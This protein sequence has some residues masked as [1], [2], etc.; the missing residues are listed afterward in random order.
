MTPVRGPAGILIAPT[1]HRQP[2]VR[3][4][5]PARVDVETPGSPGDERH[6]I[7]L[8][9]PGRRV[10]VVDFEAEAAQVSPLVIHDVDLWRA[11]P[12]RGES[13][14]PPGGRPCRRGVDRPVV[15]EPARIR[16]L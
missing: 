16:P 13:D 15:R 14:F 9:G 12:I 8:G 6:A 3:A 10:R 4:V 2:C 7:T 1:T 5:W 11:A